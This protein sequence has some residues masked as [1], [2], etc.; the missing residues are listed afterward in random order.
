MVRCLLD[1]SRRHIDI[2]AETLVV[3][4]FN[5][6]NELLTPFGRQQMCEFLHYSSQNAWNQRVSPTYS[7]D[8]G[9]NLRI[10]YGFLLQV[11]LI[12]A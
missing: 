7:D 6:G 2:D 9:V 11:R 5:L 4:E 3:R 12:S 8:L 10:K 1:V